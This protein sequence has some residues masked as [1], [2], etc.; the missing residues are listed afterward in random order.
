YYFTPGNLGVPVFDVDGLKVAFNICYDRHFPELARIAALEGADLLVIPAAALG[1]PGRINTWQAEMIARA[2]EN[3]FYVLGIG[4][5]GVEDGR[6][7]SGQSMLVD[8][9]GRVLSCL[10]VEDE[11]IVMAEVET[12]VVAE[13][14]VDYAHLR[15]LRVE[16]YQR[17]LEL[18]S[19]S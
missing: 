8:P 9:Y 14:R 17:L 6:R 7:Y 4:R 19:A 11:G 13:A 18:V 12:A 10:G 5:S 15:D 3:V 16:V 2:G 1:D